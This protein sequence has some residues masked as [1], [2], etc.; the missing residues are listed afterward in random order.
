[1]IRALLITPNRNHFA[2][3]AA[4][5]ADDNADLRWETSGS[6]ALTALGRQ[7]A[8]LVVADERLDDMTGL[9]FAG[10]LVA[11]NPMINCALVSP[12]AEKAFHEASEGLGIL[13]Q[14]APSP[15]REEAAALVAHLKKI[16]GFTTH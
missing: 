13:M 16:I 5:L 8:D 12:L 3:L 15:R 14:L 10:R 4:T 6:A 1:M 2:A 7:A 11:Q 9:A